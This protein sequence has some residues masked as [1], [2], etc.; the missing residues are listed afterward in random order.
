M[1]EKF[2]ANQFFDSFQKTSTTGLSPII[3][4][5][6]PLEIHS[7]W[8][9]AIQLFRKVNND[10]NNL[11]KIDSKLVR[12]DSVSGSRGLKAISDGLFEI[13]NFELVHPVS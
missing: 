5:Q 12:F 4:K 8:K 1:F 11:M 3:R 13:R 2:D 10:S 7:I 6:I 9:F